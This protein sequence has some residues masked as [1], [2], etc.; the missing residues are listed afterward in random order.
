MDTVKELNG[1]FW[2]FGIILTGICV[3]QAGLFLRLA[4]KLNKKHNLYTKKD[5]NRAVKTS[6]IAVIGPGVNVLF[7]HVYVRLTG[8]GDYL[9]AVRSYRNSN[10]RAYE[11]TTGCCS[12]RL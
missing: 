12:D 2:V 11:C 9:Y 1:Q 6:I 3:I 4:L 5:L 8:F 10:A 7:G